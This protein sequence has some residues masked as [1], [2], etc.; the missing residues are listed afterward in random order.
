MFCKPM[1]AADAQFAWKVNLLDFR[2]LS[3]IVRALQIRRKIWFIYVI[4]LIVYVE[5]SA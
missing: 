3:Y 2:G 1:R 4:Y 5:S